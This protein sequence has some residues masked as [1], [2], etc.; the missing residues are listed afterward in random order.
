MAFQ[1]I[2]YHKAKKFDF[3]REAGLGGLFIF[4]SIDGDDRS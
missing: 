2:N 3:L 1:L 4:N